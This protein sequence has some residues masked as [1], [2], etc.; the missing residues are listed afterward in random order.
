MWCQL[1]INFIICTTS[2]LFIMTRNCIHTSAS[3]IT[4][5]NIHV[6]T[7]NEMDHFRRDDEEE[8]IIHN[9]I[10]E[11]TQH[12]GCFQEDAPEDDGNQYLNDTGDGD[13]NT[14]EEM[15]VKDDIPEVTGNSITGYERLMN[16]KR[17]VTYIH[18]YNFRLPD[19]RARNVNEARRKRWRA[20][21]RSPHCT[22][23]GNRSLPR[24]LRRLW[25]ISAD[26]MSRRI[27]PLASSSGR[28]PKA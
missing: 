26:V 28:K 14:M 24:G 2:C 19:R 27:S 13:A 4:P 11:G 17:V 15:H 25:W 1:Y 5:R 8:F 21:R 12:E 23:M 9:M 22:R 7:G 16:V 10:Q 3:Y 20:I 6:C 18:I